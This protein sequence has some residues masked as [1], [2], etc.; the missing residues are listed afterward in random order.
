MSNKCPYCGGNL[1]NEA[2]ASDHKE[3]LMGCIKELR[4]RIDG[5]QRKMYWSTE[6][7]HRIAGEMGFTP[8][9]VVTL[10][11]IQTAPPGICRE[12]VE[13]SIRRLLHIPEEP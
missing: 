6:E 13:Y 12:D 5:P 3:W 8:N 7:V 10:S 2:I 9:D 1:D 4:R 11:G